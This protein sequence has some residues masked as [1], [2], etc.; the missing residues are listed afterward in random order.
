MTLEEVTR[1]LYGLDPGEFVRARDAQVK[2]ARTAG[3]REL[4]AA[5]GKLRRPT[6]AAWAVNLLARAAGEEVGAL[7]NLGAALRDAQR[8]LSGDEL[9]T[10]TSQRQQ[11]VNALS[12]K[13]GQLAETHGRPL[14]E[15]VLREIG[16]TLHAALADSDVAEQVRNGTLTTPANY[17]GFGPSGPTLTAAPEPPPSPPQPPADRDAAAR[18][19]LDDALAALESA[20]EATD[21]A[22][23]ELEHR[24]TELS[25][26]DARIAALRTDLEQ[27]EDRRRF[28]ASAERAA[29]EAVHK[30]ERQ[31]DRVE[32]WVDKARSRL[33]DDE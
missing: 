1:E 30:A 17:E 8:R 22:R 13:A 29:Q 20:R 5:I 31:L 25:E 33:P 12:H 6:V 28:A 26:L 16:Q 24:T 9:R 18:Q 15:A 19:E 2:A 10:L 3:D 14:G 23:A 32:R 27:A 7:L 4:A 21:S 11:V